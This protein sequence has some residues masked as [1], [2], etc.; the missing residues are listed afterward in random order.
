MKIACLSCGHA[1]EIAEGTNLRGV[2][3]PK[4]GVPPAAHFPHEKM[5]R[6][7]SV[8]NPAVARACEHAR[9]GEREPALAALE[10]AFRAGYDD[11]ERVENDPALSGL[12]G[13]P[14]FADLLKRY[15]TR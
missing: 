13:D 11:F 9:R 8:E 15:R 1:Y 3:C 12:R 5:L 10:E 4:C 7:E 14:R 2:T 6:F